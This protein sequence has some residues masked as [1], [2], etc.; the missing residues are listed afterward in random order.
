MEWKV[1][2]EA[3]GDSSCEDI[4]ALL[5]E[6]VQVTLKKIV[7]SQ[8]FTLILILRYLPSLGALG[9]LQPRSKGSEVVV[10]TGLVTDHF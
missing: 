1:T 5:N 8:S 3:I 6:A 9:V 7:P 2:M 4:A 10:P